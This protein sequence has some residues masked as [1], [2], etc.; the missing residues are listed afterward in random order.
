MRFDD[1]TGKHSNPNASQAALRRQITS[2]KNSLD[3]FRFTH[4]LVRKPAP[5]FAQ[6]LTTAQLGPP[7]YARALAQHE[8]YC[9][10]LRTAG[11]EL[12]AL[13]PD[14]AFPDSCFVEDTA[15]LTEH[16]AIIARPGAPSRQGEE[17]AIEQV[18]S[19][20]RQ[21]R[22]I[23]PPGTLDGG[24]V[25]QVGRTFFIG[26]SKRTN[27]HGAQQ[28][29]RILESEGYRVRMVPVEGVLHLKTGLTAL[30]ERHFVG[31]AYFAR[32][33]TELDIFALPQS[34]A[35]AANCL[36]INEHLLI[37]EGY[38]TVR[39]FAQRLNENILE[40]P[41]SEFARMDGG[42]TCLSLRWTSS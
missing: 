37:P 39:A 9:E 11:L 4:A 27:A 13:E 19:A 7:D 23:H 10:A 15:V 35:Y 18:L 16:T 12:I 26:L 38:P 6:G 2:K 34:E 41:M 22:R 28:L 21:I 40:V 1:A 25:L 31:N 24:D 42:L 36:P 5:T 32:T 17:A 20:F 8:A 14:P 29:A 30:D 33:L 3:M